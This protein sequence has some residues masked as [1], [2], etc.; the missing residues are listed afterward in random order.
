[1]DS[2]FSLYSA[3][4][5]YVSI[6]LI[7]LSVFEPLDLMNIRNANHY[8]NNNLNDYKGDFVQLFYDLSY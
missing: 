4:S 6:S 8:F 3:N 7:V 5:K 1:M 2:L